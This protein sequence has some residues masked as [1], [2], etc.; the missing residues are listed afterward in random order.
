MTSRRSPPRRSS[1]SR[2]RAALGA[3]VVLLGVAVLLG[4]VV[5]LGGALV[6]RA[7]APSPLVETRDGVEIDW[8]AGTVTASAG[9]AA[10]LRMPSADLARPGSVRRAEATARARL[11]GALAALPLGAG[12]TLPAA[13]V[14]RTVARA[15]QS[16]AEYQSNGGAFVRVTARFADWSEDAPRVAPAPAVVLNVAAMHLAAAPLARAAD[17]HEIALRAATYR[18]GPAPH[19]ADARAA[20]VDRAGR[21][22]LDPA[23]DAALARDLERGTALIYVGKVLK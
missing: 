14:A 4:G 21:L 16:G 23:P 18:V 3:A 2:S 20:K 19:A 8:A 17:A 11:A 22:V 9:A 15:R 10:D 12:R 7:A 1:G 13:A 5:L 6:A